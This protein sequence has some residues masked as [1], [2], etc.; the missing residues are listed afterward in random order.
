MN[1][2]IVI[3]VLTNWGGIITTNTKVIYN[4]VD[5][6][7]INNKKDTCKDIAFDFKNNIN[8]LYL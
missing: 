4:P 3:V 2:K 8:I 5:V 6:E 1:K 7:Y